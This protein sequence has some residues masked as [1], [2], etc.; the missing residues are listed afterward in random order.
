MNL[1][2]ET[3]PI[4]LIL[5]FV[6]SCT[7]DTFDTIN[8]SPSNKFNKKIENE[9]Y[10]KKKFSIALANV[11]YESE[12]SRKLIKE[13]VLKQFDYEYDVLYMLVKDKRVED[14]KTFEEQLLKFIDKEEL[15]S[16]LQKIPNLT[17]FVPALP[18]D[19]FS[20][21]KWNVKEEIPLVAYKDRDGQILYTDNVGNINSIAYDEIPMFPIVVVKPSERVFLQTSSTRNIGTTTLTANNGMKFI[22][23]YKEFDN[24]SSK[25]LVLDIPL[26]I[27]LTN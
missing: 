24:V 10:L 8:H 4:L 17:I 27:I 3:F 22:F 9:T 1:K 2:I 7:N 21:E 19:I 12:A 26:L 25:K 11:F 23:E 20:P 15:S 14:G 13:E 16:L 18:D 6:T 5:L